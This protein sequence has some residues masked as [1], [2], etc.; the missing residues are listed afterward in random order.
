MNYHLIR[1]DDM[2][3]G[4]GLRIVLFVS[5]CEHHCEDCHNPETWNK[6]SGDKFTY[7]SLLKIVKELEKEYIAG[8]TIS[9]GD[10]LYEENLAS[11]YG[12]VTVIKT[13]FPEK[14]IW[15]Y[16]GFTW[17][18]VMTN[19]DDNLNKSR[20]R[21][22]EN[23]DVVCDGKFI[24]DLSDVNCPWVGSTNQRVIDVKKSIEKNNVVL[25]KSKNNI[26]V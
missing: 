16:T 8:I 6:N 11:I 19:T 18:Y 4:D 7:R 23:C 5:G 15:L 2:L 26:T 1:T 12:L 9:G 3:N 24:K 21:I 20:K 13:Y 14:D 17:E 22:I 25:Y 10:P